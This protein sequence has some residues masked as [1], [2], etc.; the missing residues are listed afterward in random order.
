MT[1][2]IELPERGRLIVGTDLQG[3]VADFERLE[4]I[5]EERT[6]E[7]DGAVLVLTGDL[8]HGPEIPEDHWPDYL[9]SYYRGDS[10]GVLERADALAKRHPRRV[11]YL[12]GNHEHAH[13]GGPVVGKFFPDEAMRLEQLLGP[14]RTVAMKRW[15]EGW[16][17]AAVAR[18]AGLVLA[19]AAPCA[20]LESAA[21]LEQ[22]ALAPEGDTIDPRLLALLWTRDSAPES[23]RACMR[24]LG[25]E[26]TVAVHGH[27]V[28]RSGFVIEH[29][30]A[31]CISTSFG[32]FDGDKFYLDWALSERVNSSRELVERGLRRLYP[33]AK[34]VFSTGLLSNDDRRNSSAAYQLR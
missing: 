31:L 2:L 32:C 3:N 25:E 27:D 22:V 20:V 4:E 24:A 33:S 15:L 9:G 14:E 7:P 12:L 16:P 8:V 10:L 13:V 19:H 21:E 5:F 34:P 11:H 17:V 29:E 26:L 30:H 23:V 28:A 6:R 18:H 1:R